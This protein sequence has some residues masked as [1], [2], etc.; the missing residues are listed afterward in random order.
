VTQVVCR[1]CGARLPDNARTCLQCG[2]PV[3]A[4]GRNKGAAPGN[5][6][7]LRPA[8]AGGLLLGLMSSIPII[9]AANLL[10]G[11]WILAGGAFSAHLLMKQ[12]PGG[13][14]TYGD[15]AFGGVLSGVVGSVVATLM[16]APSKIFFSGDWVALRQKTEL[17]LN[18]TP[19]APAAMRDLFLRAVSPEISLTTGMF[20]FFLFGVF[21]CLFAMFG[22]MLMVWVANRRQ[23]RRPAA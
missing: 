2:T 19:D 20:W 16:L 7:F 22:G 1:E 12:R 13:R 4:F 11:A 17:Q 14:I 18:T 8:L 21:F 23:A 9:N 15:G 6:E 3:D 10:F 5:L